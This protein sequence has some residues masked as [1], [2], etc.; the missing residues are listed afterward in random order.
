M[1]IQGY[2]YLHE[3]KDLIYKPGADSIIDI[4]DSDLCRSAWAYDGRRQTAWQILVEALS[5]GVNKDRILELAEKWKCDNE[6]AINYA[7]YL[8]IE[9]VM[10]GSAYCARGVNFINMMESPHGF[11]DNYLEAMADFCKNIGF[12]GGKMWNHTFELL[13]K[14]I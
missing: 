12:N 8:G 3:N 13:L 10:D 14:T 11:G 9:L 1:K 4:R 6:D 7:K 5:L 2:Y